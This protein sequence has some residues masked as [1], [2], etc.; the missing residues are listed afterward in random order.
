MRE[1][2]TSGLAGGEAEINQPSLPRSDYRRRTVNNYKGEE[3]EGGHPGHP[4]LLTARV[5]WGS[6]RQCP[7]AQNVY[8]GIRLLIRRRL[9][10][11]ILLSVLWKEGL[12]IV[13]VL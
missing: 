2:R 12:K 9:V 3:R 5:S 1:I 10:P 11:F 4:C 13:G 6:F 8:G 7:G